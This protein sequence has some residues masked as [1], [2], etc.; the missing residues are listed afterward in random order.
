MLA[1]LGVGVKSNNQ[2]K[3]SRRVAGCRCFVVLVIGVLLCS[4]P[5]TIKFAQ[6]RLNYMK[7]SSSGIQN[8]TLRVQSLV[9]DQEENLLLTI[10]NGI[11]TKVEGGFDPLSQP[12]EYQS[13]AIEELFRGSLNCVIFLCEVDYDTIYGF[14]TF[15]AQRFLEMS[16]I[17]SVS[18]FQRLS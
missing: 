7:W 8:Y 18:D 14:P 16:S 15:V 6:N 10:Q 1:E 4:A 3:V 13:L 17:I 5:W 11:V 12:R 9:V 2:G